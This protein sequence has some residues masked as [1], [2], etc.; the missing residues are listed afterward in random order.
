MGNAIIMVVLTPISAIVL[1][2]LLVFL[3]F[4]GRITIPPYFAAKKTELSYK[5]R[6]LSDFTSANKG[7]QTIQAYGYENWLIEQLKLH[8]HDNFR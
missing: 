1:V 7:L 8:I 4:N 2:P 3:Y 5:S 6:I